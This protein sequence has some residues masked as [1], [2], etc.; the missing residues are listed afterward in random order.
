M[1]NL[2]KAKERLKAALGRL[3]N[4]IEKKIDSLET[5]N[6]NLGAEIT[7][8]KQELQ[9]VVDHTQLEAATI[10]VKPQSEDFSLQFDSGLISKQASKQIDLSLSELK[11]LVK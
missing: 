4:S 11:K 6:H 2:E 10:M 1:N 8:L 9:A 7:L 5:T 3:E